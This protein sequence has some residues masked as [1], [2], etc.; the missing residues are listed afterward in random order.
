MTAA[1]PG[2]EAW[3][4]HLETAGLAARITLEA[5]PELVSLAMVPDVASV[6]S[7]PLRLWLAQSVA[8]AVPCF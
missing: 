7:L 4:G 3:T 1:A 2:D 8:G 6:P 5:D